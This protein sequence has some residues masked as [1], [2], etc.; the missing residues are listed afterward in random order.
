[1]GLNEPTVWNAPETRE[2]RKPGAAYR[3]AVVAGSFTA[4]LW[5]IE[6]LDTLFG[7][8]LERAGIEPREADGLDGILFA[9]VLHAGW[10]HLIANTIPVVVL[11]FLALLSG[12]ARG[13]A[14][15]AIIWVVGGIGTW[16]TGADHTNHIGASILIFGWI[17]YLIAQGLFTRRLM[18]LLLGV[19][20]LVIYGSVLWGVLPT[21]PTVS[22]QGH[23][24]GAIGGVLA[25]WVVSRKRD[26]RHSIER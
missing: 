3:A 9:P 11:L 17:T 2:P 14:A 25:A 23:L 18:H 20:V 15:T 8:R 13:L 16:L 21:L 6:I 24:F 12:F 22:W 10:D 1:M 4:L 5:V 19:A 7:S 26:R